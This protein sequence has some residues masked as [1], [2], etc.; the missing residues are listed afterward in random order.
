M[1]QNNRSQKTTNNKILCVL[2]GP[3]ASGKSLIAIELAKIFSGEI[4]NADAIQIYSEIPILSCSPSNED[5]KTIEH[6]L[7]NYISPVENYSVSRFIEDSVPTIQNISAKGAMP[8]LVGGTGMYIKSL[9]EGIHSIPNIDE[10]FKIEAIKLHK[11]LGAEAFHK[12]LMQKDPIAGQLL[13]MSNTQRII[14]AYSVFQATGRSLY[15]FHKDDSKKFLEEY[16]IIQ[17]ILNP[18]RN[19]LYSTCNARFAKLMENGAIQEVE[20]ITRKYD[21]PLAASKA[22]GFD[23]ISSYLNGDISYEECINLSQIKTRNYAK[24]Q[25]TWFRHQMQNAHHISF[26]I[27]DP[28]KILKRTMDIIESYV[29]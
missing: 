15:D 16:K 22:I 6:H 21:K 5:K 26:D 20:S 11:N 28:D 4:I 8:F 14:R 12:I 9:C 23:Q 18:E 10:S 27:F 25:V 2:T 17:L 13:H 7:Y 1:L 19:L 3:T 29:L 24:R